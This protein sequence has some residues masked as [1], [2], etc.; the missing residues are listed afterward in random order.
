MR[1]AIIIHDIDNEPLLRFTESKLFFDAK[2]QRS[3]FIDDCIIVASMSEVEDHVATAHSII[4][5]KTGYYLTTDFRRINKDHRGLLVVG[6]EDSNVIYF[7]QR[8]EISL[9]NRSH[10]PVGSK[11]LYI[12]ENFLKII[13][14]HDKLI[15]VDNTE[16]YHAVDITAHSFFGL[17]S[18]WKSYRIIRDIGIDKLTNITIYDINPQQLDHARWLHSCE[19]LPES[20]AGYRYQCGDY[21]VP[22]DLLEFWPKYHK[23]A[24]SFNLIDL[25][26]IPSFP[27]GSAIWISNVFIYE[28][29]IFRHGWKVCKDGENK[30]RKTNASCIFITK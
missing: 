6:H 4:V 9:S 14:K 16:E 15:Y 27:D 19:S 7:D 24:V 5:I 28:P 1:L 21:H 10:Y 29:N 18:G 2:N 13:A 23:T 26:S 25:F 17:A 8:T 11:Q 30:L 3:Y 20:I 22:V 12:I